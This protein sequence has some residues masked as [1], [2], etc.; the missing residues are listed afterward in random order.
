MDRWQAQYEFWS[1]F[2]MPAYPEDDVPDRKDITFPYITYQAVSGGFGAVL[3]VNASIW[4]RST[5]WEEA[6]A[7]A[8]E[9]ER[10]IRS[11]GYPEID[12]GRYR[13]YIPDSAFAQSMGD[14]NDDQVKRKR[15]DVR[16][17]FMTS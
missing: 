2:G 4:T 17:E 9:I 3:T 13:V 1:S 14:P 11:M 7:K 6:D 10:Y 15:L 12:G 16:F 5:S 8:D